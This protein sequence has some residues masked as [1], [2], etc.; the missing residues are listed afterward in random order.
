LWWCWWIARL[1]GEGSMRGL[2]RTGWG[3][4]RSWGDLSEIESFDWRFPRISVNPQSFLQVSPTFPSIQTNLQSTPTRHPT[5]V[6]NESTKH[7][8]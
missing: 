2:R 8:S 4:D 1:W 7:S 6:M 3:S 5:R